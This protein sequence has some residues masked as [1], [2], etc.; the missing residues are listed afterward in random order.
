[1]PRNSTLVGI[2]RLEYNPH[3]RAPQKFHVQHWRQ[4]APIKGN[5]KVFC[6]EHCFL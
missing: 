6:K 2:W 1:M 3:L 5:W 4:E